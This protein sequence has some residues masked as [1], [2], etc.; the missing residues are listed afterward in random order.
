M[1]ALTKSKFK[2]LE[3][4]PSKVKAEIQLLKDSRSG[5]RAFA[6][7]SL[8]QSEIVRG[9]TECLYNSLLE[10]ISLKLYPTTT[11]CTCLTELTDLMK[12]L[13]NPINFI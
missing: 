6:S 3:I 1:C 10:D 2:S 4:N 9:K 13:L 11:E 7:G 12:I 8:F 5:D